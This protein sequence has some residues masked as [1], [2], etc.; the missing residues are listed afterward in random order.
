MIG[1]WSGERS[2]ISSAS[3]RSPP[4]SPF[5]TPSPSR[6]RHSQTATGSAAAHPKTWN[7]PK[8]LTNSTSTLHSPLIKLSMLT[9]LT[10]L[11]I[12][13]NLNAKSKP[14]EKPVQSHMSLQNP[15]NYPQKS[16]KNRPPNST[17]STRK[18][19]AKPS[20]SSHCNGATI[21]SRNKSLAPFQARRSKVSASP[22][23]YD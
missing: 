8:M 9:L 19:R 14:L 18:S 12:L 5:R 13:P 17:A 11:H 2:L 3:Y 6:R 23:A 7:F 20:K 4:R 15:P 16:A 22:N 21:P 10:S 1:K